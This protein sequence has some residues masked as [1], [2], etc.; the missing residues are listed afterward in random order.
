MQ[1]R[2]VIVTTG[3]DRAAL[4][5]LESAFEWHLGV[6]TVETLRLGNVQSLFAAYHNAARMIDDDNA[7]LI[8]AHQDVIPFYRSAETPVLVPQLPESAEWLAQAFRS[9]RGW[10]EHLDR[11]LERDDTGF[12]GVAG[13]CDLDETCSWWNGQRLSGAMLHHAEGNDPKINAYGAWG[14][15]ATLDGVLLM[16]M[17]SV[18][19]RMVS[20]APTPDRFHFYDLELCLNAHL[21]GLKNWTLPLLL[22]HRSGGATT[23]DPRWRKDLAGFLERYPREVPFAVEYEPLTEVRG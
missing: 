2:V 3:E 13:A 21:A 1:R 7:L 20:P 19:R 4:A 10:V 17:G 6:E 8:F 15:V 14:R 5:A 9:P 22:V 16:A 23:D 11:L 12:L 18:F